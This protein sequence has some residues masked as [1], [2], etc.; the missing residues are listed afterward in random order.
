[1][2]TIERPVP[3]ETECTV[4]YTIERDKGRL[5]NARWAMAETDRGHRFRASGGSHA[6]LLQRL[7]ER[8]AACGCTATTL[9]DTD[10]D[11]HQGS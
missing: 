6:Q 5:P 9:V 4:Q 7:R 1:M 11:R 8:A 10:H 3:K 2:T